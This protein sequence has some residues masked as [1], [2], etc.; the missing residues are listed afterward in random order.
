MVPPRARLVLLVL[1]VLIATAAAYSP[2]LRNGFTRYDD[3]K[4]VTANPRVQ[5][6]LSAGALGWAFTTT[7]AAN[8][9]PL[10]WLSHMTDCAIFGPDPRGHH[11]T[12]LLLHLA[13]TGLLLLTL[14]KMTG[15]EMK[16]AIVAALFALHPLH[17]ESVA[18]VAERKDVLSGFFFV[19]TL[20]AYAWYAARPSI[21]RY[22]L[23][24]A[25]LVAGLLAKPMLVTAPFVFLLLDLWPLER[26]EGLR[27]LV[28][29]KVPFF[30]LS[31][32][33]A[34]VTIVAQRSGGALGTVESYPLGA[35]AAN[36]LVAY[37]VYL[38]KMILPADLAGFYPYPESGMSWWRVALA[39]AVLLTITALA[40]RVR[41][42][43]PYIF[44]GWF[45]YLGMLVPVIGLVQVGDQALADRYTYLPLIGIF[46]AVVWG[47]ASS[48]E[49]LRDRRWMDPLWVIRGAALLI[50]AVLGGL[51]WQQT[52]VWRDSATLFEHALAAVGESATIH[53]NL[54]LAL[55][56]RGDLV[57]AER[58]C[59]RALEMNPA[60]SMAHNNLGSLLTR[61]G[62]S[63]EAIQHYVAALQNDP[64]GA[65]A[66]NNLAISLARAGRY[67][68]A[69]PHFAAAVQGKP[70]DARY[71]LNWGT[72]LVGNRKW[73][74]AV[75]QFR[76]AIDIQPD[77][78]AA[79]FYLSAA[80]FYAGDLAGARAEAAV[81]DRY[82]YVPP[83]EF[84]DMLPKGGEPPPK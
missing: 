66:H 56:E 75:E 17:V 9:H 74:E 23:V 51:T 43:R 65:D 79:H 33:S 60:D 7:T 46:V 63:D 80:L 47:A 19:L 77:N 20:A 64:A 29:E 67:D 10:T 52:R 84:L 53:D 42:R 69:M 55:E 41:R 39:A 82:G 16:S 18:W 48:F 73:P 35:R 50:L 72:A 37:V 26:K 6:G 2:I 62:R 76:R 49:H 27:R 44:I 61:S 57:G 32:A 5:A 31:A 45:W 68:E 15:E 21:A 54:A 24:T 40:V 22:V 8:W 58:H 78:P 81:A 71:R 30:A 4:Y 12:S 13:T 38:R 83:A 25:A 1:T 70:D 14:R 3:D 59:R 11:A 36:A 28:V 34:V